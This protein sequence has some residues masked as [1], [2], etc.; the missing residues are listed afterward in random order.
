MKSITLICGAILAAMALGACASAPNEAEAIER[1]SPAITPSPAQEGLAESPRLEPDE[2][3]EGEEADYSSMILDFDDSLL[4]LP[5]GEAQATPEPIPFYSPSDPGSMPPASV[6][7]WNPHWADEFEGPGL[8]EKAWRYAEGAGG[9]GN[10]ELQHYMPGESNARIENGALVIEAR[11][12]PLG[13]N[14]YSS[15]RIH[16][17]Y[18]FHLTYG[19]VETRFRVELSQSIWP[20]IWMMGDTNG[21]SWPSCGEIDLFEAIGSAPKRAHATVHGP[22]Y[23]G[24][25]GIGSSMEV[26]SLAEYHE[27]ALEWDEL[28][29]RWYLDGELFHTVSPADLPADAPWVFDH[30]F[31]FIVNLAVGG[32][33][34][35]YPDESTVLPARFEVDY[36]RV[37]KKDEA[38]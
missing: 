17:K 5:E 14:G 24:G 7:G 38:R 4:A 18:R 1:T 35:G 15:A 31:Y 19:R 32:A 2:G 28:E 23:S 27:L 6:P 9:W 30:D 34:P 29:L 11:E 26:E 37:Y 25:N 16:T 33:W 3:A 13:R 36:I 22:G 10:G 20:A 12:D 21:K 8:D